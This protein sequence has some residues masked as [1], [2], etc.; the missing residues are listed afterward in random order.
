MFFRSD[1]NSWLTLYIEC[2][3]KQTSI[4]EKKNSPATTEQRQQHP[5]STAGKLFF[6]LKIFSDMFHDGSVVNLA[7]QKILWKNL[8]SKWWSCALLS[9]CSSPKPQ[10]PEIRIKVL[11]LPHFKMVQKKSEEW[12]YNSFF[13]IYVKN[14]AKGLVSFYIYVKLF[15][16]IV[17][18][19]K[20]HCLMRKS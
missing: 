3:R 11:N 8:W 6:L 10:C 19:Q 5:C 13:Y 12:K 4:F 15:L 16:I 17:S 1:S 18:V 9:I 20:I 7:F 14:H 2:Y